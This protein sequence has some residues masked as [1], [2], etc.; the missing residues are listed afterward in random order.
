[1][2]RGFV[3]TM[4][5][6]TGEGV[7]PIPAEAVPPGGETARI[8]RAAGVLALGNVA[9]RLLGL[10]RETVKSHF[11]GAGAIVDA[12]GVATAVPTMLHDLLVGGMVNGAL[13]PVF[14]EYAERDREELWRLA[15]AFLNLSIVVLAAIILLVE[16]AAPQIA[17]LILSGQEAATQALAARLLRITL[18][19]VLFLSLSAVLSGLLYALKRFSLPAFTAA[20]FNATIVIAAIALHR[21]LGIAALAVGL[22]AG[23]ALQVVLQLPGLRDSSLRLGLRLWHPGL[24]RVGM[25]YVPTLIPLLAD[26]GLSRPI[27]YVLASQSGEGGIS[28]LNYATQLVQMPQG[29]VATAISLA[30][31]PT[32]SAAA[33]RRAA[34]LDA[35]NSSFE[36]TL[37][38]GLRLVVALILPAAVGL[39]ILAEP[40]VALLYGH[41]EF[42]ATDTF[43]TAWAL[44]YYLL[45]LPFAAVDLLLV[46]AFYAQQ[47]TLTP[48]LIGVG[49]IIAYLLLAAA[50]LPVFG[51]FSLMIA[52]S[53][54][55][56]LHTIFSA[57]FLRRRLEGVRQYGAY[58]AFGVV[59]VASAAMGAAAYGAL[60]GVEALMPG[61]GLAEV[62]AVLVPALVGAG[63]YLGLSSLLG[64]EEIRLLWAAVRRRLGAQ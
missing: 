62:L 18:P 47:D 41:G 55:H 12:Y 39:F 58:R 22:L 25:L 30:V 11:F 9:S 53:V 38:R 5:Q 17:T 2:F 32:L 37:A 28:Y 60:L 24:R 35:G 46:Y 56:L 50:L 31:L 59:L 48:S 14:S 43:M 21:Q 27:S 4:E 33:A 19:A 51:L 23:S 64:L 44:R 42:A 45:G 52:D 6:T 54:K 1:M 8:A 15:S 57:V 63:V 34:G 61:G 16:L 36:Q 13:V 29:L 3:M 26:V 7:G 20:V 40:T 10:A 49:T